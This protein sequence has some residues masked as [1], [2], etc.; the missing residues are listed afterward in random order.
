MSEPNTV[1]ARVA[2]LLAA[3]PSLLA[4]VVPFNVKL[5]VAVGVPVTGQEMVRPAASD[6]TGVAGVQV[7]TLRPAGRPASEHVAAVAATAGAFAFVQ[8]KLPV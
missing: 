1:R 4:P 8:V 5:P 7:P 6:A 2:V 3:T